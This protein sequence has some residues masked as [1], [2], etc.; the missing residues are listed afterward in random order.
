MNT[1]VQLSVG[2][3]ALCVIDF[4][5]MWETVPCSIF[6]EVAHSNTWAFEQGQ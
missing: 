5:K 1:S 6:E 3:L 2:Y 4:N